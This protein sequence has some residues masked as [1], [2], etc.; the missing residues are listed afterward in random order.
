[1]YSDGMR[2]WCDTVYGHEMTI[3]GHCACADFNGLFHV[4]FKRQNMT[5]SSTHIY[6]HV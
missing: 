2:V 3:S 1:M 5:A 6:T 4:L